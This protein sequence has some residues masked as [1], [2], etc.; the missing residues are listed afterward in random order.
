MPRLFCRDAAA[1]MDFCKHTFGAVELNRRAGPDGKVA[2]GLMTISGEMIMIEAEWP[3]F[4]SRAPQLD[5]SSPVGIF[6]YVE[7]VDKAVER[8]VAVGA[9]ILYP[10]QNQFWGDR[11][12]WIMD[13]QG[14][15]WTIA[16][17]I[18]ETTKE[19]RDQRWGGQFG[20]IGE[21]E[22]VNALV[23]VVAAKD[24]HRRQEIKKTYA[25]GLGKAYFYFGATGR[26][27]PL[28]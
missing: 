15:V 12:G 27:L 4:P 28:F 10:V 26:A 19:Q 16:S 25:V 7:D 18:E 17:R 22:R 23:E 14:H 20:Q 5:G 13:P 9:K 6:V 3:G 11:I 24:W 1:E 2:H 8:S 21:G